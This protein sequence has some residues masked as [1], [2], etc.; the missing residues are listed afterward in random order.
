MACINSYNWPGNVR[1]L[2]N[3]LMK[4]AVME[5]GDTLTVDHLPPE[6]HHLHQERPLPSPS[7]SVDLRSLRELERHHIGRVLDRTGWHK[8]KTCEILSR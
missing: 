2:E 1:Q 5:R 8:G 3:A 4:P 6:I 7:S